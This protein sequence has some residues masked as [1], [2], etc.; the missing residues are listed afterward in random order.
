MKPSPE[1]LLAALRASKVPVL[2]KEVR[3]A[4]TVP[5]AEGAR[6]ALDQGAHGIVADLVDL[7]DL[8]VELK[9]LRA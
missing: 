1:E 7:E 8:T 4:G 6:F 5:L 3:A 2:A 9:A